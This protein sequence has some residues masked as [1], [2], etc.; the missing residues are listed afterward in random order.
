MD[1]VHLAAARWITGGFPDSPQNAL[2]SITSLDP[3]QIALDKLSYCS[4]LC[5]IMI[6][7]SVGVIK[8]H[9]PISNLTTPT[10]GHLHIQA[11]HI[12]SKPPY[13][14][15]CNSSKMGPITALQNILLPST[16]PPCYDDDSQPGTHA[17]DLYHSQ[18]N[19]IEIPPKPKAATD[20]WKAQVAHILEPMLQETCLI[21]L[22]SPPTNMVQ[23]KGLYCSI[24]L[25]PNQ[26]HLIT[27]KHL[28][29]SNHHE[30]TLAGLIDSLPML[31][32]STRDINILL[33]NQAAMFSLFNERTTIN[34][35]YRLSFNQA[36]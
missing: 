17:I 12:H 15:G 5:L 19:T 23:Q 16:K 30:L 21:I 24:L 1:K 29:L 2:L 3:L 28:P 14:K 34:A 33:W 25:H 27:T 4:A 35:H 8:G 22:A 26:P 32:Q 13:I 18:I 6:H 7:P 10:T 20:K 9:K 36:I 31:L 11:T